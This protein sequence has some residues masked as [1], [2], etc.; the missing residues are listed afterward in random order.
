MLDS[1]LKGLYVVCLVAG[2][3]IRAVYTVR[4]K[5]NKVADDYATVQDK[6]LISLSS[7][8][9]I[10][11]P[12]FYLLSPWLDFADYRLPAWAG[13]TAGSVGAAVFIVALWLLWR[14][15]VDLGRN[16]LPHLQIRVEHSLITRGMFRRIRH[17]MYAAHW[18]W[19]IAQALLLQNWIAGLSMLIF[20]IPIYLVR[21]THEE[22]MMLEHFGKEY[23]E[24]MNRTG[25]VIP[26]LR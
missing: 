25:R 9:L 20:F 10:V 26:L 3:V 14:S 4:N 18:L 21:V 22:R 5:Q 16:W 12:L 8:G 11:I 6:L 19:G 1:I 15:H 17:P 13:L 23:R 24:Y 2:S 7:V